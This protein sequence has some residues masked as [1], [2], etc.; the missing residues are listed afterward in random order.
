MSYF[1]VKL[2]DSLPNQWPFDLTTGSHP[3]NKCQN[4]SPIYLLGRLILLVGQGSLGLELYCIAFYKNVS[5]LNCG[6]WATTCCFCMSIRF[7]CC[8]A[9]VPPALAKYFFYSWA[10]PATFN[11]TFMWWR[12]FMWN[13]CKN[14]ML[15]WIFC[16]LVVFL[17]FWWVK[18]I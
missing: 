6:K 2:H 5:D 8:S 3:R 10:L 14:T 4:T 9:V 12:H 11:K 15:M 16:C 17:L 7:V 1:A 18:E 13:K